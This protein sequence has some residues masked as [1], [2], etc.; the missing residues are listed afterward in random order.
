M[1]KN[2]KSDK[3]VFRVYRRWKY[4]RHLGYSKEKWGEHEQS[5]GPKQKA[6]DNQPLQGN[7][8]LECQDYLTSEQLRNSFSNASNH[9]FYPPVL[10]CLTHKAERIQ[11]MFTQVSNYVIDTYWKD[12][13]MQLSPQHTWHEK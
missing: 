11:Y 3:K 8:H 9:V 6:G 5:Q 7:Q 2:K 10:F 12:I 4:A 13:T 1:K